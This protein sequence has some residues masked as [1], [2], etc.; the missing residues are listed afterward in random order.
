M[1]NVGVIVPFYQRRP[2][3]LLKAL[4]S[5]L[6][7][8]LASD[9]RLEIVVVD[10][11][12]PCPPDED[13]AALPD[14]GR[15]TLTELKQKNGG[16]GAARNIALDYFSDKQ[17]DFIAFIDSDDVWCPG[18][19]EYALGG[20]G[21]D[22]DYFFSNHMR[23][24]LS[25]DQDYFTL[26]PVISSWF[27]ELAEGPIEAAFSDY[28]QLRENWRLLPF[29]SAYLSQTSGVVYRHSRLGH[30]RFDPTLRVA[31]EDQI[32]WLN[33]ARDA[34]R[35]RL[36]RRVG[37]KCEDGVNI[38]HATL[39]WDHPD[40]LERFACQ[41]L[42][43]DYTIKR[44]DL[45]PEELRLARENY[46]AFSRAFSYMWVRALLKTHRFHRP[47]LNLLKTNAGWSAWKIAP[48]I[49]EVVTRKMTGRTPFPAH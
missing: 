13:I 43:W 26:H 19:I 45:S 20:L 37:V 17:V 2:G 33:L 1:T 36:S 24:S 4:K 15:H 38:F 14:L 31:G 30:V 29:L 32:F 28:F 49:A 8:K 40:T 5:V 18:H 16:P 10:D 39:S 25:T 27:S 46:A 34:R 42:Q 48:G 12:S 22:A 3:L 6:D 47:M 11:E 21:V 44:F 41:L 35:V 9:T 7:Q 23:D